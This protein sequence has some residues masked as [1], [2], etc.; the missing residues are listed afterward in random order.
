MKKLIDMDERLIKLIQDF[1][2]NNFDGNFSEAVRHLC[3]KS[4]TN[5]TK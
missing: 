4:L 2:N 3:L 5:N 1:A